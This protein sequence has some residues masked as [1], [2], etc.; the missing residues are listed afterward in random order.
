MVND[1]VIT[2]VKGLIKVGVVRVN[3]W[4]RNPRHLYKV[5][6][7]NVVCF[8]DC[9]AWV[10]GTV[11]EISEYVSLRGWKIVATNAKGREFLNC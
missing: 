2:T 3:C 10:S 9:G 6:R 11:A 7:S 5:K 1:L 8:W 4:E